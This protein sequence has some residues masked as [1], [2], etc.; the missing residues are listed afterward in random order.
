[1]KRIEKILLLTNLVA[2]S[3]KTHERYKEIVIMDKI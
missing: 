2:E 1:M 3:R